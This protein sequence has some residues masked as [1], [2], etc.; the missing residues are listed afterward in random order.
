[1][2]SRIE[3]EVK[4]AQGRE[5]TSEEAGAW[6]VAFLEDRLMCRHPKP[7]AENAITGYCLHVQ[8][9]SESVDNPER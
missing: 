6:A 4:D 3:Y 5:V 2:Q 1:M 9:V 7:V 8:R